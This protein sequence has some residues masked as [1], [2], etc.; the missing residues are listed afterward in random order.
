MTLQTMQ[1]YDNLLLEYQI[2]QQAYKNA[3]NATSR[4]KILESLQYVERQLEFLMHKNVRSQ[5]PNENYW[6]KKR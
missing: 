3:R 5:P 1:I 2:L 4:K 6:K